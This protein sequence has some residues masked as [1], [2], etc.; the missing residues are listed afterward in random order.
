MKYI[1]IIASLLIS[2]GANAQKLYSDS[3]YKNVVPHVKLAEAI[4]DT[5]NVEKLILKKQRF[6]SFPKEILQMRELEYLDLSRN[7]IDSIPAAISN[8][9]NLRV[10]I[11]SRNKLKSI[12]KEIYSLK[13]L[14]ILDISANDI[15]ELP[16]GV[17]G[18]VKLEEL[19]LWNTSVDEL[20]MDIDEIKTLKVVDMRGVLLNYDSQDALF[21]LL[22]NIKLYTSPPCNCSF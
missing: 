11:I 20:P 21:E 5:G 6:T 14:K 12:P 15:S 10:L 22:P 8:L 4:E 1:I 16:Q 7:K 19:N 9:K 13:K 3:A 17:E 18:L 2:F